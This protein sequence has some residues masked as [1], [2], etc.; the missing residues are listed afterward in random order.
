VKTSSEGA[1]TVD[2][3]QLEH[4]G[5]RRTYRVVRP[6][7]PAPDAVLVLALH[8]SNQDGAKLRRSSGGTFD[9]LAADHGAVVVYPDAHGGLWND[10]R[11]NIPGRA[12]AE[13]VDDVGFL[14]AVLDQV[15]DRYGLA[16]RRTVVAGYSNGGQMALRL[17]FQTSGRLRGVVLFGAALPTPDDLVVEDQGDRVPITVVQGTKDPIVPFAGGTVS[18][19]GFRPRGTVLP[20]P[21]SARR[22]ARRNR[23][24]D[25]P[26]TTELPERT[27]RTTVSVTRYGGT[28]PVTLYTVENGGHVVPNR[29]TRAITLLGRTTRTVDGGELVWELV[30]GAH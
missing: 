17:L 19:F 9:A 4:G 26:V 7:A 5:R 18:L 30:E 15:A 11:R 13:G 3:A 8:G 2:E 1:G 25:E 28:A 20:A 22:L 6:A 23:T 24:D 12:R 14:T 10:A 29:T 21:E 27:A 16:D